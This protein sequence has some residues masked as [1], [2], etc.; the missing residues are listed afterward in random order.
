MF[1]RP[2]VGSFGSGLFDFSCRVG[3]VGALT[4]HSPCGLAHKVQNRKTHELE[5]TQRVIAG[6]ARQLDNEKG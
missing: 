1:V 3:H 5:T 2:L 6:A 4:V